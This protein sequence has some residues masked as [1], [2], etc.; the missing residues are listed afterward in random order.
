MESVKHFI[1]ITKTVKIY[2]LWQI[3]QEIWN[4]QNKEK[5]MWMHF[6]I[7]QVFNIFPQLLGKFRQY[8]H[9]SKTQ[10]LFNGAHSKYLHHA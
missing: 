6:E 9:K 8:G 10:S 5:L 7:L 4:I 2:L 3:K 1:S